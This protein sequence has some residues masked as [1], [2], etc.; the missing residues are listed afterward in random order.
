MLDT[1]QFVVWRFQI[2]VRYQNDLDLVARF[3]FH[4]LATFSIEQKRRDIDR[5]L[6]MNDRRTFLHGF[7]LDNP[8]N[9]KGGRFR[10]ANMSGSVTARAG[11]MASF[12]QGRAQPLARQFHQ[13]ETGDLVH[14]DACPVIM[15]RFLQTG[16]DLT[17]VFRQFHI[18]EIDHDQ[19]AEIAQ[20]QLAGD[21]FGRLA[22]G[23]ERGCFDIRSASGTGRVTSMATSASVWSMTMDPPEGRETTRE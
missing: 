21:F 8:E 11:D 15:Q 7:F 5:N 23:R 20:T 22:I 12:G 2:L 9:L 1:F 16:L 4:D 19:S 3:D 13:T 17:P 14:L 10:I 18:D 6:D